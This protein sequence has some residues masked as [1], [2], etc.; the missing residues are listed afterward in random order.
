MQL[1][2]DQHRF[3][4]CQ[5]R[6]NH[7]PQPET[8]EKSRL[9]L[10][11]A[12]EIAERMNYSEW[13]AWIHQLR[14]SWELLQ[15]VPSWETIVRNSLLAF[16]YASDFN[17]LTLREI[18]RIAA[19]FW[20]A[21]AEDG[22]VQQALAFCDIAIV[23]WKNAGYSEQRPEVPELFHNLKQKIELLPNPTND[24][25]EPANESGS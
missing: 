22:S 23:A 5:S 3:L 24:A 14:V 16:A 17:L 1:G 10:D 6:P 18:L 25:P 20:Y 19:D 15:P 2:R 12:Q 7:R 13:L 8:L 21:H 4:S 9:Y 11:A